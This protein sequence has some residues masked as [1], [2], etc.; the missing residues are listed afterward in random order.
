MTLMKTA[1]IS[2]GGQISIPAEIRHRW[3]TTRVILV[4]HGTSLE[5]RPIPADPIAALMGSM[6]NIGPSTDEIRAQMREEDA[7]I[8]ER[9]YGR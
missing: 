3:G 1:T 4:D 5:L 7:E 2:R 8:E 6:K 9:K